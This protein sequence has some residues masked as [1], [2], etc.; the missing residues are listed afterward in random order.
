MWVFMYTCEYGGP[1]AASGV[2]TLVPEIT[3]KAEPSAGIA[4]TCEH[5]SPG[6]WDWGAVEVTL[7]SLDLQGKY[8]NKWPLFPTRD[9][10]FSPHLSGPRNGMYLENVGIWESTEHNSSVT[11]RCHSLSETVLLD[12]TIEKT[13]SPTAAGRTELITASGGW[14]RCSRKSQN[15]NPVF[16]PGHSLATVLHRA[17]NS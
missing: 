14:S 13:A 3:K 17:R 10:H 11:S 5:T 1:R 6:G 9:V 2:I 7:R 8:S 12:F 15:E 16:A 4:R